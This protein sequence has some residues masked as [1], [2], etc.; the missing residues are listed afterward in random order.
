MQNLSALYAYMSA[1]LLEANLRNEVAMLDEVS[2]LLIE[3]RGG[4]EAI[5]PGETETAPHP[6]AAV[7]EKVVTLNGGGN[8]LVPSGV[9]RALNA[10]QQV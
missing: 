3:L 2:R 4:W 8:E 5:R 9:R 7:R 6:S 10:Y 1:R